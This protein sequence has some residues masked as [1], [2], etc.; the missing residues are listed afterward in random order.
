MP[1]S[2]TRICI[3]LA[4]IALINPVAAL[5]EQ[6]TAIVGARIVD[7]T[8]GPSHVLT[9]RVQDGRILSIGKATPP[10]TDL[11]I[12]GSGLILAPGFIDTHSHHDLSFTSEKALID[13]PDALSAVSQGITTII[14]GQDGF[15]NLPIV[16]FFRQHEKSPAAVNIASYVGHG[17]VRSKIM[18]DSDYK[19][20]AT[21]A[22]I[23]RMAALVEADMRSGALGLSTGLEYDPA[24]YASRDEVLT[25]AKVAA[26]FGG[27]YISHMRSEDVAIDAAI[28]E[29][30][31][32]G[33]RAKLPVQISHFKLAISD[34]WGQ[35]DAVLRKLD[36]AR[37]QGIDVTAD[38]YPYTFWQSDLTV[39]FPKRDFTDIKASEFALTHL[40]TPEGM[41]L[42]LYGP[43]PSLV[44]KT[45]AQIAV[46]RGTSPA[47][48]YL[49][50]INEA[51]RQK[52]ETGVMG[53]SMTDS[54]VASLILWKHSNISSD[55]LLVDRHPRGAGSFTKVLRWLVRDTKQIS[56]ETAI[57][58]MTG[59]A[60]KH[61]GL[62]NRGL[63]AKGFP[64]DLV[65]FDPLTVA[66]TST[67]ENP[68]ATSLGI[69]QV[70]VN[71]VTVYRDGKASGAYPGQILRRN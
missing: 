61:V 48:T 27:R 56:F 9:V 57:H 53:T 68:T 16:D 5:A 19:R 21:P 31:D 70:W 35:A 38:V 46:E 39:L 50:L 37:R 8:G 11:V 65:L 17:A 33:R 52:K 13:Q 4:A 64:A 22:E 30:L 12:D 43:D 28:D 14:V 25:L 32:I 1:F 40:S 42:T 66:D 67:I 3:A 49:D 26:R 15:S 62:K 51:Q 23:A 36:A 41:R 6:P 10:K 34:K 71:G 18:G 45:I 54:D 44:G 59:L 7:G 24:I 2:K 69:R 20:A 29:L 55:G 60:A 47:Q 63:I 58:K